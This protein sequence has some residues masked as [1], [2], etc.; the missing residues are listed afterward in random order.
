[1]QYIVE[2]EMGKEK[3][4]RI[5]KSLVKKELGAAQNIS[6]LEGKRRDSS[7][8]LQGP[9]PEDRCFCSKSISVDRI[10]SEGPILRLSH[11]MQ[12]CRPPHGNW[13]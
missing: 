8:G 13:V 1:M 7:V 4:K 3:E 11:L 5:I 2:E 6:G 9:K 10:G 12:G